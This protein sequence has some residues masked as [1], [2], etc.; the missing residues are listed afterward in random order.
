MVKQPTT[1]GA[2]SGGGGSGG[3]RESFNKLITATKKAAHRNNVVLLEACANGKL[4]YIKTSIDAGADVHYVTEEHE[5]PLL[6]CCSLPTADAEKCI[7]Y[8]LKRGADINFQL[9][10]QA[11]HKTPMIYI[12][13]KQYRTNPCVLLLVTLNFASHSHIARHIFPENVPL[14]CLM[15]EQVITVCAAVPLPLAIV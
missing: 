9:Y 15:K 10:Q 11:G 8:L 6:K 14:T 1:E 13:D 3:A 4:N 2:G 5:T 7:K 12:W